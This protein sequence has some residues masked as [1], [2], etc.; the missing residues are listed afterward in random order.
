MQFLLRR[1]LL[2]LALGVVP[3]ASA[4]VRPVDLSTVSPAAFRDDELDLPYYL[5]HFHRIANSVALTGP[6]RGFIDIPVWRDLKDNQPYNARI[7]ESILSLVYFYTLDRPWNPYRGDPELRTRLEAALDFWCRSQ[8]DDGRFSEYAVGQWSLAPT[9]F[10]TKFMGESLRLLRG[11]PSIDS[12][13]HRRVIAADRK[14]LM[15]VLTR[16]DMQQHGRE[17][18]NQF[19]NAFAGALAYVDLYPDVELSA[20]LKQQMAAADKDHQSPVGFFYEAGGPDWGYDLNTHHS[21]FI[22]AWNYTR[23]TPASK[24]VVGPMSRW[25][26]WFAYNAV[27]EPTG[28][29]AL[30]LNRAIETRQ[31][32]GVVTD[33]GAGEAETGNP[34]TEVVVGARVLGPT[35]EELVRRHAALRAELVKHWPHVDSL[36]LGSFRAFS[37]YAFLHRSHVQWFPSDSQWLAARAAMRP[38]REQRFT[39]QR[40]DSR[41]PT[42]FT[43][44]RRPAYYAAFT[45]GDISTAQQRFGLGLLWTPQGGTF[46]QSQSAGTTTAWGTRAADTSMVYEAVTIPATFSVNSRAVTLRVGAR[47]LPAGSLK[48][49]YPLRSAGKKTIVFDDD[50]ANVSIEHRGAFVEQLPLLVLPSDSI[51]SVPGQLTLRRGATQFVVR[52]TSRAGATVTRT[53]ERVGDRRVVVVAIPATGSLSYAIRFRGP[54]AAFTP[55]TFDA[56][57]RALVG[58]MTLAEKIGQMTQV[59]QSFLKDPSDIERYKLGSI[60]N[61]GSSDPAAGNSLQAWRAMIETYQEH[62]MRTRLRIPLVYGVDAVHGNNNVIGAVVFPHNIGLGATRDSALVRRV[63]EITAEE[64]R[65][66]GANWAFAPCVCVPQDIRWGRTYEGFSE[67]P[68]LVA[69]LGA[70]AVHGL[71]GEQPVGPTHVAAT[72]KHFAGDGGTSWGTGVD[73]GLDQ[74][75]TRVDSAALRRIHI[76]PYIDAIAAGVATIMPSY[77]S[78]NGVKVSGNGHLL[79]DVLKDELGFNGFLISDYK[80]VNQVNTDYKAAIGMSINAGMDMVMVPDRYVDFI[81]LLTQLVQEGRVPMSRIDDAVTRILR[82]KF[83]LGLMD[84]SYGFHADH[85]LEQRFGSGEHRAVARQAVRESIVLLKNEH[86]A[87]PLS[88]TARRIHVVGKSAD[89][90]GIQSGGWT[91]DWQGKAGSITTGGTTILAGI[92]AGAAA[93]TQVTYSADGSGADGAD[94]IVVVVGETPYAEMKGDRSELTLD[95][96]DRRA[97][98]NAHASQLPVILVIVSGRPLDIAPVLGDANAILAAWL[99]GTEGAG[100][101]DVLFGDYRPTGKLSFTWPRTFD[102]TARRAAGRDPLFAFGFGLTYR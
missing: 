93:S 100:V 61:G 74:G 99:P 28:G 12:A 68:E 27:P 83:A 23:G 43:F 98:E 11:G 19:S 25:Y 41:K 77:N 58:R 96:S 70:A 30:T 4:Q 33:A 34:I 1:C 36:T 90:I 62:A 73:K 52:W 87:L 55:M 56:P 47:D 102:Q 48:I 3:P 45:T 37:P 40:V 32:T 60:L 69:T 97:L 50:G 66:V 20:R 86:D 5:A 101:A 79:T 22:M 92:R 65:A 85:S 44:V 2:V 7:M 10:A 16:P 78:W 18:T 91:I 14:A 9:A 15:A 89:D 63:A 80:A 17:Y 75:D 76:R 38:Q 46:L 94:A 24:D 72:A 35:R 8:N 67:D 81:E 26:D 57:A 49:R 59:D 82:V 6:R 21:N 71:Q 31:R 51:A 64:T 39:H 29:R 42:A 95:A 88:K 13:I 54:P 84:P 53:E